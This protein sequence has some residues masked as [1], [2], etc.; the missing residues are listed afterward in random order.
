MKKD[1]V[2]LLI[3]FIE[4]HEEGHREAYITY[5][6]ELVYQAKDDSCIQNNKP[7]VIPDVSG[8][9]EQLTAFVQWL[10]DNHSIRIHD[11]I[12]QDYLKYGG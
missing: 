3:D 2:I 4:I 9:S 6:K 5:L 1:D 11:M 8:R 10:E 7:F 12:L